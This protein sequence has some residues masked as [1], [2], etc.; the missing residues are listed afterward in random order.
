MMPTSIAA[1]SPVRIALRPEAVRLGASDAVNSFTATVVDCRYHGTQTIYDLSVFGGRIE[2][3]ELST[4][5]RFHPG[6]EVR[7]ML[8]PTAIWAY[9]GD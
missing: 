9:A 5:I 4:E 6:S 8:P 7:I 3:L 2:A 1:G